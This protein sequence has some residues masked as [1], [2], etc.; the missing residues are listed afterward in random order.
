[1]KISL[2][3]E[4]KEIRGFIILL[5][6]LTLKKSLESVEKRALRLEGIEEMALGMAHEIRNPLAS[7]RGCA[8]EL[9]RSETDPYNQKL[10]E[11]ILNES[12]RLDKILEQFLNFTKP[13]IF[14]F[15]EIE[16]ASLIEKVILLVKTHENGK[17]LKISSNYPRHPLLVTC[18]ADKITQAF[19]NL[20]LN[21][22]E[23]DATEL[24]IFVKKAP[25]P[26]MIEG[27]PRLLS[28]IPT[29]LIEFRDNGKG[30]PEANL[31]KIFTPFFTTKTTGTGLGLP[32]VSKI[33]KQHQGH[34]E[35]KTSP[36]KTFFQVW[37]PVAPIV[38]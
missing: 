15:K 33:L 19:L 38:K 7:V 22:I 25:M 1:M 23:A 2:L 3:R 11:I 28:E 26:L 5:R 12:D 31:K 20:A 14:Q 16:L 8:Q 27:Q 21:A 37:L 32:I 34:I 18:D 13:E 35:V 36:G 24:E 9:K 30:I 10:Q 6:D 17:N 4:E 29:I